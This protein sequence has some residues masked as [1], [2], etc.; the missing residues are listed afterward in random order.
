MQPI[1]LRHDARCKQG[2]ECHIQ[3][4]HNFLIKFHI[5]YFFISSYGLEDMN[6]ARYKHSLKYLGKQRKWWNFSHPGNTSPSGCQ[7]ARGTDV[8][9]DWIA[10]RTRDIDLA[11]E[12]LTEGSHMSA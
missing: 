8:A 11:V 6:L 4:L 3:I 7:Q 1:T 9:A 12:M 2:Y 10:D 5:K